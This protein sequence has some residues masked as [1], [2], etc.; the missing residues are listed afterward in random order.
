MGFTTVVPYVSSSNSA[1]NGWQFLLLGR[2]NQPVL[3]Y[4]TP[5]NP[6]N[7]FP[8]PNAYTQLPYYSTLQYYD[9][10]FIRAK[11]INLGYNIP[12]NLLRKVGIS[13]LRIY[14][15]VTN[16]FFIYAPIRQQSFSVPD[17]ESTFNSVPAA[18]SVSGNIGGADAGGNNFR[19]VGL[20]VGEQTRDFIFGINARF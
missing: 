7:A 12:G 10:S 8:E 1:T 17:A 6:T 5:N 3:D 11:S 14:A 20:N 15:N 16:P 2:H 4:W 19:G 13:S 9:G 18:T